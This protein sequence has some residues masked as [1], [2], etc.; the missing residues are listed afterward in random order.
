MLVVHNNQHYEPLFKPQL[1]VRCVPLHVYPYKD[2]MQ[3]RYGASSAFH[4]LGKL[5]G[6]GLIA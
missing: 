1:M 3:C 6:S 5:G 2:N 4:S